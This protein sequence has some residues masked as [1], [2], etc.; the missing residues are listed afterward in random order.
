MKKGNLLLGFCKS[1]EAEKVGNITFFYLSPEEVDEMYERLKGRA[2]QEPVI[3]KKF[4]IY[5]FFAKDPEDRMLE[6]Q[7]FMHQ[8]DPFI[9]GTELLVRRRSIRTFEET[10]VSR[11]TLLKVFDTCRY[12][13]T[14]RN[15][16]SYYFI[17]IE[18]E[19]Y[20]QKIEFLASVRG[21]SSRPISNAPMAVAICSDSSKTARLEQDACIAAYH[22]ILTCW[23][24]GLGT[25]WIAAMDR[26]DVKK[27]LGIPQTH[28]IATIT[29]VG[30][31]KKI[32]GLPSRR[33]TKEIV[34]FL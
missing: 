17:V 14:S 4:R 30:Y 2:I 7:C 10:P 32:P 27:A 16:Q 23:L 31:P 18:K 20:S 22:F 11:D 1:E 15:S 26:D 12:S 3:N 5:H 34:K 33:E 29:P 6:F 9:D 21:G 13:P 25:C 8:L 28:Y 19:N 24:H